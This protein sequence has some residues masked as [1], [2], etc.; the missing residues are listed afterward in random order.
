VN[1]TFTKAFAR[2]EALI[3][4]LVPAG[5]RYNRINH[6]WLVISIGDKQSILK[7]DIRELEDFESAIGSTALPRRYVAGIENDIRFHIL[8]QLGADGLIPDFKIS[9]AIVQDERDWVTN[10]QLGTGFN[11]ELT[12]LLLL[13]LDD[14][15]KF[16][17]STL[18]PGVNVPDVQREINGLNALKDYY[19]RNRHL[20][21]P[22]AGAENL[23]LLKAAAV[24]MIMRLEDA[25][26]DAT[27]RVKEALSKQILEIAQT[28]LAEPFRRIKLPRGMVEYAAA[29]TT[30]GKRETPA[31][32]RREVA[33]KRLDE[34]LNALDPGLVAR[35]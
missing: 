23:S 24:C 31:E 30:M 7:F 21:E 9:S 26:K 27:E 15:V 10:V 20:N 6:E 5:T 28:F 18:K 17:Q 2:I 3:A 13:G 16:L 14:L 33:H 34:L 12:K 19:V 25:R 22:Q 35:R 4:A 29:S 1:L 8:E 32:R 11:T